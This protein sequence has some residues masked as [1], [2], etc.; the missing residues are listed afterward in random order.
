LSLINKFTWNFTV[1]ESSYIKAIGHV[2]V[3][4]RAV[5]GTSE[6]AVMV[7]LKVKLNGSAILGSTTGCNIVG[8]VDHYAIIPIC[9]YAEIEAGDHTIEIWMRSASDAADGVNGLA[10]IKANYNMVLYEVGSL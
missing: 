7:A 6:D 2:D 1:T 3:K 8:K 9:A 10:E 5:S 4:H